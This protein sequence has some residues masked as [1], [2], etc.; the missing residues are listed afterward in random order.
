MIVYFYLSSIER[1]TV[2]IIIEKIQF[3]NL[4]NNDDN[5][6]NHSSNSK[7]FKLIQLKIFNAKRFEKN[8]NKRK[9]TKANDIIF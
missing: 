3:L 2:L 5:G 4:I 1:E 8:D 9:V 7:K 6:E